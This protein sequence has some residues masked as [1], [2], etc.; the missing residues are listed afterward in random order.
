MK[1]YT[2]AHTKHPPTKKIFIRIKMPHNMTHDV[3]QPMYSK[4]ANIIG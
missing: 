4:M 1:S 3:N 2:N